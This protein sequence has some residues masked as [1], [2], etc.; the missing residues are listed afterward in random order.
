M[1]RCPWSSFNIFLVLF[2][3]SLT[4]LTMLALTLEWLQ[5][6]QVARLVSFGIREEMGEEVLD[7]WEVLTLVGSRGLAFSSQE[8]YLDLGSS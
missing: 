3:T 1:P 8:L 4:H 6:C 2:N 5:L 7:K